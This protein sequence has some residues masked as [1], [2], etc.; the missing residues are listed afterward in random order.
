MVAPV[1]YLMIQNVV[2]AVVLDYRL[3]SF[4]DQRA[5]TLIFLWNAKWIRE[6]IP[7]F[8]DLLADLAH[9]FCSRCIY[10]QTF[11]GERT[12]ELVRMS[13]FGRNVRWSS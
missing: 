1:C 7:F 9:L 3:L 11:R 5:V 2:D 12:A 13:P 8:Q 10:E 6:E 4:H